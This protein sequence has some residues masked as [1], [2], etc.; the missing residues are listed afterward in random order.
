[1]R[2]PLDVLSLGTTAARAAG[3]DAERAR[4]AFLSLAALLSAI[5]AIV[6][7]PLS[8]VGLMAPHIARG[9]G[10]R[11][12]REFTIA[13]ALAGGSLM[14]CADWA[15]RMVVYPYEVPAGIAAT[16]IGAPFLLILLRRLKT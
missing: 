11:R 6:T 5:G 10:Y 9:L 2:R 3:L 13:A 16:L 4:I 15:G 1:M 7:G 8:F 12:G 14:A